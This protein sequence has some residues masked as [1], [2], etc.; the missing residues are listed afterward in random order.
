LK[1]RGET[2]NV[3]TVGSK[4]TSWLLAFMTPTIRDKELKDDWER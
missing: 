1:D 2:L 3:C 4:N